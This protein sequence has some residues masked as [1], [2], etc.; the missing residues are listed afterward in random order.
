MAQDHN[1]KTVP[2]LKA[3]LKTKGVPHSDYRK[4]DLIDLC[5]KSDEQSIPFAESDDHEAS[6]LKRRTIT[7]NKGETIILP[8][9]TECQ[10]STNLKDITDCDA[11][12]VLVYL[13]SVCQWSDARLTAWREDDGYRLTQATDGNH[14]CNVQTAKIP[15]YSD[16][17]YLKATCIP[18]TSQN[19]DPYYVWTLRACT[20][21]IISGGCSCPTG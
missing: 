16:Y 15:N 7:N 1:K 18:E 14:I 3:Y 11:A 2:Q 5:N 10:F 20:G 17:E 9:F 19:A 21:Q 4:K 12:D 8:S 6:L 13:K